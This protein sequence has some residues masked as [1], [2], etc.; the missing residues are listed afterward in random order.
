MVQENH[1]ST[2]TKGLS[3]SQDSL[4]SLAK[5]L[6]TLTLFPHLL[7]ITILTLKQMVSGRT[8]LVDTSERTL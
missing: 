6:M 3:S 5:S 2:Q 8:K 7:G 4:A 1:H